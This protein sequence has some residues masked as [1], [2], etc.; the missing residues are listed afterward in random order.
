[1]KVGSGGLVTKS[2]PILVSP[3]TVTFQTP[4]SMGFSR[5]EHW[6]GLPFPSP[7]DLPNPGIKPWSSGLQA[8]YLPTEL[9]GKSTNED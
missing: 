8:D 4:L 9:Q 5:Q 6:S 2:H 1:M 7:G 3:W